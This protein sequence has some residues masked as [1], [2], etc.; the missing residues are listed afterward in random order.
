[1]FQTGLD[2]SVFAGGYTN[3]ASNGTS[4]W[5]SPQGPQTATQAGFGTSV[6][7]SGRPGRVTAGVLSVGSMSLA[8][9][10]FIYLSLPR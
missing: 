10:I 8:L 4:T 2:T 9:L 1:M 7:G 6:G 5:A 3:M